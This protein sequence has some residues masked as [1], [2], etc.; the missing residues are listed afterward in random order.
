M[1]RATALEVPGELFA[2][3]PS[4][5]APMVVAIPVEGEA[6]AA[7]AAGHTSEAAGCGSWLACGAIGPRPPK[8]MRPPAI[9]WQKVNRILY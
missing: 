7:T 6:A 2:K 9:G 5:V 8:A 3:Q 4:F 1:S